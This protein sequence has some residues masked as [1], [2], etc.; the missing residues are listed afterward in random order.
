MSSCAFP[1]QVDCLA[2]LSFTRFDISRIISVKKVRFGVSPTT[3]RRSG[4]TPNPAYIRPLLG[5]VLSKTA[6]L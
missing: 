1:F 2:I 4:S 5:I 3:S 6:L